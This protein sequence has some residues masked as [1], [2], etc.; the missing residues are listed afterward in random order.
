MEVTWRLCNA[1]YKA[2]IYALPSQ[3]WYLPLSALYEA[4]PASNKA[5]HF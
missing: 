5:V 1:H 3:F 2:N 4:P